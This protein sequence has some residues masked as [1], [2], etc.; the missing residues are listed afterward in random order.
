MMVSYTFISL[1]LVLTLY[2]KSTATQS[3]PA[4]DSVVETWKGETYQYLSLKTLQ[5]N[6]TLFE[7]FPFWI[8]KL[9]QNLNK[10][11]LHW[12]L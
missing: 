8:F 6:S 12:Y 5:T 3:I 7:Q 10:T 4:L 1:Y 9:K 11:K 2:W